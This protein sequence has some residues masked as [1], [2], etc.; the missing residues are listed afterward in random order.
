MPAEG[1][2]VTTCSSNSSPDPPSPLPRALEPRLLAAASHVG[3]ISPIRIFGRAKRLRSLP[4]P[5]LLFSVEAEGLAGGVAV[6]RGGRFRRRLLRTGHRAWTPPLPRR[7]EGRTAPVLHPTTGTQRQTFS[8]NVIWEALSNYR[9]ILTAVAFDHC[10]E[11][12]I[13]GSR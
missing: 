5:R 6:R 3:N 13:K 2:G 10:N 4:W 9:E 11:N 12:E 1:P 8:A 7:C